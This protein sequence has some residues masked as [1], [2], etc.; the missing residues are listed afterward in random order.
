[1][2]KDALEWTVCTEGGIWRKLLFIGERKIS[3]RYVQSPRTSRKTEKKQGEQKC[4]IFLFQVPHRKGKS[5]TSGIKDC[6]S[7]K[8]DRNEVPLQYSFSVFCQSGFCLCL[9]HDNEKTAF[10]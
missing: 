6:P 10:K 2:L 9:W 4:S 3:E 1:M 7:G 8:E 5:T